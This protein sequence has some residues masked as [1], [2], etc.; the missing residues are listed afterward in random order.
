MIDLRKWFDRVLVVNL[1]RRPD[2]WAAFEARA[3][4]AGITGYERFSAVD[5]NLSPPPSWFTAGAGAWG[6][7]QSHLRIVQ[8]ASKNPSIGRYLVFEDDVCFRE[9]FGQ[10]EDIMEG[11]SF[12]PW[13]MIYFGGSHLVPPVNHGRG[14]LRGRNINR[15]HAYAVHSTAFHDLE[16]AI[17]DWPSYGP[18]EHIDDA[19]GK[20]HMKGA[21]TILAVEPWVCGQAECYSDVL[22]IR[23]IESWWDRI[24]NGT[25]SLTS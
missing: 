19:I 12:T 6:A 25:I 15:L 18:K 21:H 22:K 7:M 11:I 13:G 1:D 2:R 10:L 3:S 24:P 4:A 23:L 14:I 16:R 20:L 17:S 8:D 9:G 5:G